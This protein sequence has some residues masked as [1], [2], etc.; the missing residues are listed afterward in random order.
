MPLG[1]SIF[2]PTVLAPDRPRALFGMGLR[3]YRYLTGT[4]LVA[5]AVRI[6]TGRPNPPD[7]S[8]SAGR[9]WPSG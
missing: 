8:C 7:R 6:A 3:I 4:A 1:S 5:F 9:T 2:T